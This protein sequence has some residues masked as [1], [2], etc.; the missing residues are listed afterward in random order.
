MANLVVELEKFDG[1]QVPFLESIV[2]YDDAGIKLRHFNKNVDFIHGNGTVKDQ[3]IIRY[4]HPSANWPMIVFQATM[5]GTLH[6][7]K[8]NSSD[9][10]YCNVSV[11]QTVVEWLLRGY[12]HH[13]IRL[14]LK[15]S[16]NVDPKVRKAINI[17]LRS[18]SLDAKA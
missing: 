15:K 9:G 3:A 16:K 4:P 18:A 7:L 14:A 17:C 10:W 2:L 11:S 6:R 1:N 13:N 8:V 5:A 12:D